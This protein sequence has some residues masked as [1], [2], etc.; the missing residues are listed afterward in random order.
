MTPPTP[1]QITALEQW[2]R[3]TLDAYGT[4]LAADI[5]DICN[6]YLALCE[7]VRA[8]GAALR[9]G[10]RENWAMQQERD[11]A[12]ARAEQAERE[13][14]E[15]KARAEAIVVP[16]ADAY[17]AQV[18]T[19]T[20]ERNAALRRH[21]HATHCYQGESPDGCAYGAVDCLMDGAPIVA[22]SERLRAEV[23]RLREQQGRE[24]IARVEAIEQGNSLAQRLIEQRD[25]ALTER[26][27]ERLRYD[28][29]RSDRDDWRKRCEVAIARCLYIDRAGR[30][31]DGHR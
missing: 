22:E 19:L 8:Q 14:D 3:V 7:T 5:R 20:S 6:G 27:H 1:E 16:T 15:W 4:A 25:A 2:A 21:A 11:A 31:S 9:D 30:T 24:R 12:V 13:R 29:M 18:A 26:D 10:V 17:E 23:R 28:G